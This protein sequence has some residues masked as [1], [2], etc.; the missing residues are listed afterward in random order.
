MA[1]RVSLSCRFV[2]HGKRWACITGETK[3]R[4]MLRD[5]CSSRNQDPKLLGWQNV[6]SSNFIQ[7]IW[8]REALRIATS[9]QH[10]AN[11]DMQTV[12]ITPRHHL[13]QPSCNKSHTDQAWCVHVFTQTRMTIC[14][15][16][17]TYEKTEYGHGPA[18]SLWT[19]LLMHKPSIVKQIITGCDLTQGL[20]HWVSSFASRY[21]AKQEL[22]WLSIST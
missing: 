9:C 10:S 22:L 5:S 3:S 20:E 11:C 12:V 18:K 4:A 21:A 7:T 19:M 8:L 6:P 13:R 17:T 16:M 15:H 14:K 1:C 2:E